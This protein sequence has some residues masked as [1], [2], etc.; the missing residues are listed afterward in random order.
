[1]KYK[2]DLNFILNNVV[3]PCARGSFVAGERH[4]LEGVHAVLCAKEIFNLL[5]NRSL[6]LELEE[7]KSFENHNDG[8]KIVVEWA[9]LNNLGFSMETDISIGVA[10]VLVYGEDLG[11]FEIGTT[12]PTKMLL[13]LRYILRERRPITVHFW[14]YGSNLAIVFKNWK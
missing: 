2:Y 7:R 3:F 4:S 5:K 6:I 12:R 8:K 11:I 9:Q 13:L 14:P 1:M 10:D